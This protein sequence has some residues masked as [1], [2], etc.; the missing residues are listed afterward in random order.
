M[1]HKLECEVES[2]GDH[3]RLTESKTVE[4]QASAMFTVLQKILLPPQV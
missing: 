1:G 2:P 3:S 4:A